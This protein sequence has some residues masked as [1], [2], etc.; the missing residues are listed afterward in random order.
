MAH[1]DRKKKGGERK[2]KKTARMRSE[3]ESRKEHAGAP[4]PSHDQPDIQSFKP[5]HASDRTT[6]PQNRPR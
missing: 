5:G 4:R 2:E 6:R 3:V 1:K